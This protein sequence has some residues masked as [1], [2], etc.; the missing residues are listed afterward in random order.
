MSSALEEGPAVDIVGSTWVG[1]EIY[2]ASMSN[3]HELQGWSWWEAE[4]ELEGQGETASP[5]YIGKHEI[6]TRRRARLTV[7]RAVP[8]FDPAFAAPLVDPPVCPYKRMQARHVPHGTMNPL[9]LCPARP[10]PAADQG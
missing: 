5:G 7:A 8:D 10:S 2:S 3:K 6:R 4:M 9:I 1:N